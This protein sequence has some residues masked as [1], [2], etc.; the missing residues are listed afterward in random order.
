MHVLL[1]TNPVN[2]TQAQC[3]QMANNVA[4]KSSTSIS[5]PRFAGSMDD[6]KTRF[7]ANGIYHIY[8]D[9]SSAVFAS[10]TVNNIPVLLR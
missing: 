4:N 9:G 8:D 2:V 1:Q 3:Q 5:S 6:L 10:S 7:N